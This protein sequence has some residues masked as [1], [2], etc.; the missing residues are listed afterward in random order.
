MNVALQVNGI[1]N[2]HKTSLVIVAEKGGL[3]GVKR[4]I[5][6]HDLAD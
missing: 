5:L 2:V 3:R 6:L 4:H 1:L